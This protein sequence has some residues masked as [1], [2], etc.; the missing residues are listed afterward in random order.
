MTIR[1]VVGRSLREV[2]D[3]A[4]YLYPVSGVLMA[5]DS[6][7]WIQYRVLRGGVQYVQFVH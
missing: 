5:E 6:F 2:D 4:L 3:E 7:A 1:V